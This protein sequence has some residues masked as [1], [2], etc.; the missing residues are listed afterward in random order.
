MCRVMLTG[1]AGLTAR[2]RC[3]A[4]LESTPT[5]H[6]FQSPDLLERRELPQVAVSPGGP[7]SVR[8]PLF[9]LCIQELCE[10]GEMV[11]HLLEATAAVRRQRGEKVPLTARRS[12]CGGLGQGSLLGV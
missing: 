8:G 11:S 3:E 4:S 10:L 9:F 5:Q 12:R 2:G 1:W 7:A 6:P